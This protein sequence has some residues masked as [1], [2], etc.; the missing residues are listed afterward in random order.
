MQATD[1][2][3]VL[4]ELTLEEKVPS[5]LIRTLHLRLQT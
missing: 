5:M 3:H 2:V 4:S 1:L